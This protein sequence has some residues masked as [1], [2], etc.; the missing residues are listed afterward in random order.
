MFSRRSKMQFVVV[1][2]FFLLL[3]SAGGALPARADSNVFPMMTGYPKEGCYDYIVSG[4]PMWDGHGSVT[5]NVPGPVVDAWLV[6]EGVNDTDDPGNPDTNNLIVNGFTV[7]GT[8]TDYSTISTVRSPWYQ[9]LADIGPNGANLVT[10]GQQTYDIS[11]WY[12][13]PVTAVNP[14]GD[15]QRNG[16]SI[17]VIYDTGACA[18]PVSIQPYY[19]SDYIW[20]AAAEDFDGGSHSAVHVFNVQPMPQDHDVNLAVNFAGADHMALLYGVCR[21]MGVWQVSGTGTP[22]DNLFDTYPDSHGVNG[23]VRI[24]HNLFAM[25]PPCFPSTQAPLT[26]YSGGYLGAEWSV[27]NMTVTVPANATWVAFQ[28]ES[29]PQRSPSEWP[30]GQSGAWAG[31]IF[32]TQLPP[33]ELT[34]SKTDH[35]STASPG[36]ILTDTVHYANTGLG[37]ATD[38]IVT[39]TLPAQVTAQ[40]WQSDQ[41]N[42]TLT[43]SNLVCDLGNLPAGTEGNIVITTQLAPVFEPG[44]TTIVNSAVIS[45]PTFGDD[46]ANNSATDTTDV[47]ATVELALSKVGAPEPVPAGK[48]ITYT[49]SWQVNGNAY[50][51]N[52]ILTDTVPAHVSFVSADNGGAE[53]GGVVQWSLGEGQPGDSGTVAW[54]GAV[55][56]LLANGLTIT[57]TARLSEN[58]G[59]SATATAVNHVFADH[60]LTLQKE[61]TPS[62]TNAGDVISYTITYGVNGNEIAPSVIVTDVVPEYMAYVGSN[63]TFDSATNMVTWSLGDL[64]PGSSD[65]VNMQL[66]SVA[67]LPDGFV[68]TNTAVIADTDP[69]TPSV[70]AEASV[71]LHSAYHLGIIGDTVWSDDNGNGIQDAGELG[72]ANVTLSLNTAGADMACNTADDT[73][74]TT[75][76]TDVNGHYVFDNLATPEQYCVVVTDVNN[77]LLGYQLTGGTSPRQVALPADGLYLDAD[78][79][80]QPL[81]S[82][83]GAVFG[84]ADQ[85]GNFDSGETPLPGVN[86][87]LCKAAAP[88]TTLA[89]VASAADGSFSFLNLVLGDYCV[90]VDPNDTALPSGATPTTATTQSVSLTTPNQVGHTYFG[91]WGYARPAVTVHKELTDPADGAIEVGDNFTFTIVIT[92]SGELPLSIV[93]LSDV[94]DNNVASF[95]SA[96]PAPDSTNGGTLTWNNLGAGSPLAVGNSITVQVTLHADAAQE[97]TTNTAT[98]SGAQSA[99]GQTAAPVSAQA[100]YSIAPPTAVTLSSFTAEGRLGD[101]L[102]RW[103]TTAEF[104]NWGFNIYRATVNDPTAAVKINGS[105]IPGQGQSVVGHN[106]T[107]TDM[108][109]RAGVTYWYWLEDVEFGGKTALHGPVQVVG[110]EAN[111]F[112][113]QSYHV[114]MPMA[115]QW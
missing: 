39:D 7:E 75:T 106:Y 102:L 37:L 18:H 2:L 103:T 23:G 93:P 1:L 12:P 14:N 98:I 76:T 107:F 6:W 9:W 38:V 101:V 108:T 43:G 56:P 19:G 24:G 21:P 55:E 51:H 110:A 112:H 114:F 97:H 48:N 11:E 36:N 73:L 78:F 52:L 46:P 25:S 54:V 34:I 15:P 85:N 28:L 27:V 89:C 42:C 64:L 29:P 8:K 32:M 100:L 45:T 10:E 47:V 59:Q 109:V 95:I 22:P 26:A 68:I 113:G 20:W 99:D 94:F 13:L 86:V 84:D 16:V 65:T 41:G 104:D 57:N 50:A 61:A 33:P 71:L 115:T 70:T 74:V 92:N 62:E 17:I 44:T 90:K 53:S 88:D 111:L 4:I 96:N 66:R 67:A 31:G 87:C 79:G 69:G 30:A 77:V 105:L 60:T 35:V 3:F 40:S 58:S 82:I 91:F 49:L 5:L 63:G 81:A 80:Y 72:I 83:A